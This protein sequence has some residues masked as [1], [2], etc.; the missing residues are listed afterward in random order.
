MA[1]QLNHDYHGAVISNA[2]H[3]IT[4]VSGSKDNLAIYVS[5]YKDQ[6]TAV[7]GSPADS[8][9]LTMNS[10]QLSHDDGVSDKNYLKQAYQHMK[11]NVFTD[12]NGVSRD[13]SLAT[14]V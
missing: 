8:F 13:Y 11:A 3:K 7:S 5:V 14:D 9:T 2:Y 6:A 4:Q 12:S 10:S 1:L